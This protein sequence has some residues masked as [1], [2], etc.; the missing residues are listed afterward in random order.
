MTV[1]APRF[2]RLCAIV[3][4]ALGIATPAAHAQ[5]TPLPPGYKAEYKLSVVLGNAFPWG[6]GTSLPY[7]KV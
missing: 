5:Q 4:I 6:K 3:A 1:S 2:A 7:G